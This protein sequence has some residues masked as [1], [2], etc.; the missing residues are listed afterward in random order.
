MGRRAESGPGD[1]G[2]T[3][4]GSR[5]RRPGRGLQECVQLIMFLC[6]RTTVEL[7]DELLRRAKQRAAAEGISLKE[8]FERALRAHLGGSAPRRRFRLRWRTEGGGLKPAVTEADFEHGGR[9]RDLMDD[10][11]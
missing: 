10:L 7:N 6:V 11:D 4:E 1:G 3:A 8:V 5:R 2:S 9:L